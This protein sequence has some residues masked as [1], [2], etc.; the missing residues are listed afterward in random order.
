[1]TVFDPTPS[2]ERAL[3]CD[4]LLACQTALVD[5]LTNKIS[6]IG[7]L[8]SIQVN[9]FPAVLPGF[10]VVAFWQHRSDVV[11]EAELQLELVELGGAG[12][13]SRLAEER[14]EFAGRSGH[15]SIC[16]VHSL[17]ILRPGRYAV[18]ARWR[19]SGQEQWHTA[20][21]HWLT[22]QTAQTAAAEA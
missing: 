5:R 21:E 15:R 9:G 10:H 19:R 13:T 17:T 20:G 11:L 1:M 14:I 7:V 16:I 4:W 22:V 2:A 6:L 18:C 3:R 8:E 12:S